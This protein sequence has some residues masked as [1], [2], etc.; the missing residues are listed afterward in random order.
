M[1]RRLLYDCAL[2]P[3][4][5]GLAWSLAA[6]NPRL[7]ANLLARRGVAQRLAQAA[8]RRDAHR[9]LAWFHVASAGEYLQVEPLLRRFRARGCQLAVT[10]TSVS[11]LR[12]LQ[13]MADWPELVYAHMA[14][15][16]RRGDVRALL[17]ALQPDV[18]VLAQADLWPNLVLETR[19]RGVPQVLVAARIG[20]GATYRL[21][22]PLRGLY[23]A[24]YGGLDA[25]AAL[26][27]G[28]RERLALLAPR[29]PRLSVAGDPG[30]ETVLARMREARDA[31]V[32]AALEARWPR[33]DAP[34]LIAGSIWP[35][36]EAHLLPLLREA[37]QH[38]PSFTV[39][40]V[41]HEPH[42]AHLRALEAALAPLAVARL[43]HL[44]APAADGAA[45]AAAATPAP[46][47]VLVDGIGRLAGLYVLASVAYVGGGFSTGVHNVA[48]PAA[49]GLPVLFGPRHGKSP[50]AQALCAAGG[51][52]PVGDGPT[53]RA[54]L[55]PLLADKAAAR[56][57]GERARA[58]VTGMAG[59]VERCEALILEV[60][61]GLA[62]PDGAEPR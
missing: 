16:D 45:A 48:E 37:L 7:R 15:F 23:R 34:R 50:V 19:A 46:R 33:R 38:W 2:V 52:F 60:A 10:L 25:I 12:W 41:P 26:T 42:E 21:R 58:V 8:Q 11:G 29:H 5:L 55:W 17:D 40:L 53:L 36:D 51:G 6:F 31:P 44:E 1:L 20:A 13:R 32:T 56:I 3:L 22:R 49:A 30:I 57:A 14:P 43:S 61:P 35:Q 39:L 4:A 18:L 54:A 28:D 62:G 59:A 9:P 24:L 27:P 47:V